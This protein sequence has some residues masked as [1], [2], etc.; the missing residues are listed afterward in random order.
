MTEVRI[1]KTK[2]RI[3][4]NILILLL[5]FLYGCGNEVEP[6]NIGDKAPNFTLTNLSGEK[7]PLNDILKG[8]EVILNFWATWCPE[9]RKEI[10]LLNEFSK[11][12]NNKAEI[13]GINLK[14]S[15][16]LVASFSK[17]KIEYRILLDTNGD[18]A[19][20]YGVFGIPTNVLI[21]KEGLIKNLNLDIREMESYLKK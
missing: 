14:E 17:G 2:V 18:V 4:E 1:Q 9:C 7:I 8:K 16:D 21:N 19:R 11:K 10:P 13:V 12:F 3:K 20:L 5:I 15:Q 6:L